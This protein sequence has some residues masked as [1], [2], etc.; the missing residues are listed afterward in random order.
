MEQELPRTFVNV[1]QVADLLLVL[2]LLLLHLNVLLHSLEEG[3]VLE[4]RVLV[5]LEERRVEAV[6]LRVAV[7]GRIVR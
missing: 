4:L 7:V 2:L 1:L 6:A 3:N 5:R